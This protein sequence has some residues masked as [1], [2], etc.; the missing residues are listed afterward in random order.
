MAETT[1]NINEIFVA[2]GHFSI[3]PIT[4]GTRLSGNVFILDSSFRS[5]D[6]VVGIGWKVMVTASI[7]FNLFEERGGIIL[8]WIFYR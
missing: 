1:L 3:Q 4:V 2:S 7:L 6:C 8:Y 5:L